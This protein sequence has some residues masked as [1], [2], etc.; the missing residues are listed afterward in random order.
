MI[1]NNA[2]RYLLV[3]ETDGKER[4]K[5]HEKEAERD[6]GRRLHRPLK[7]RRHGTPAKYEHHRILK[8]VKPV[9]VGDIVSMFKDMYGEEGKAAQKKSGFDFRRDLGVDNKDKSRANFE[10]VFQH[11]PDEINPKIERKPLEWK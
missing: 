5:Q 8:S 4:K 7:I 10:I 3:S 6:P 2:V 1:P 11:W 9:L